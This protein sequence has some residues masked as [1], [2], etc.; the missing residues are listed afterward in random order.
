MAPAVGRPGGAQHT[1]SDYL[2]G[3]S[4]HPF[5]PPKVDRG[6]E[7]TRL[8]RLV[9]LLEPLAGLSLRRR[10]HAIEALQAFLEEAREQSRER[11]VEKWLRFV[12]PAPGAGDGQERRGGGRTTE[13]MKR[14]RALKG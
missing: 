5:P 4:D 3:L 1:T 7:P 11:S 2:L 14:M 12:G 6:V 13:R 9:P 8:A 10:K